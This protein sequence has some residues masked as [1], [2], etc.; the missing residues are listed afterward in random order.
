VAALLKDVK[1]HGGG[2][3]YSVQS[4]PKARPEWIA[5][6]TKTDSAGKSLTAG[7]TLSINLV[8]L[9][10]EAA[11]TEDLDS[12]VKLCYLGCD[13]LP[14]SLPAKDASGRTGYA[15]LSQLLEKTHPA[16]GN[17]ASM[18]WDY[19]GFSAGDHG[20]ATTIDHQD[21]KLLGV[22]T[23]PYKGLRTG[24]E[25]TD[26]GMDPKVGWDAVLDPSR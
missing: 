16:P 10:D 2:N 9:V 20:A 11:K 15:R 17:T 1:N 19:P 24:F 4:M 6:V 8:A 7:P 13:D 26:D 22:S 18:S 23:P 21:M 12:L 5:A 3:D 25:L 14:E